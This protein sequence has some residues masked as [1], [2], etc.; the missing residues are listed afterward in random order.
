[1]T[2][3]PSL[4]LEIGFLWFLWVGWCRVLLE[5]PERQWKFLFRK[6]MWLLLLVDGRVWV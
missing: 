2:G 4:R 3:R 5:V 6:Q 1:M